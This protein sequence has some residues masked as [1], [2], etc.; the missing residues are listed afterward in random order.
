MKHKNLVIYKDYLK[1]LKA[2]YLTEATDWLSRMVLLRVLY[3]IAPLYLSADLLA[4]TSV[5]GTYMVFGW[6]NLVSWDETSDTFLNMSDV[7]RGFKPL[8]V[9]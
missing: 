3:N 5:L 4:H 1:C 7:Y 2:L 6:L 8:S 9:L